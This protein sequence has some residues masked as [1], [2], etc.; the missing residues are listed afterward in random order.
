MR[1]RDVLKTAGASVAALA[2]PRIA[3]AER[4]N[5]LVVVPTT[6]L[7]VLDPVVTGLRSTRNHAYLVFDTL[8]GIDTSWTAQP[9]M[10]EGHQVEEDGLIW[11][12]T[13]RDGLR[14]HD[15]EPVL[16][17]DVVASIRRFAARISFANALMAATEELSGPDDHTVRFRLKRPFP[18]LPEA[19]AGPGA[20]VPA[21]MPERLAATSPFKPVA[22]IVGSGPYRFLPEEHISGAR[23]AYER[24]TLYQPRT[25]GPLGFTSGPKIAHFDRVEW[26][27]LDPFS[28]MAALQNGE[29]DWWEAPLHDQ[30]EALTRERNITVISQYATAM[31]ILRFNH[32]HPPFNNV[33]VRRALLGAVDQAEAMTAVAGTDPAFWR[34][35][36]GLFAAG[37][38]LANDAGVEVLRG[39][40]DYA[41][42]RRALARAGYNG[43]K[44][45]V[46]A[47]TD[48]QGIRALSLAGTDQLRRAGMNVDLQEMDLGTVL[49]RRT[50]QAAPDKGGWNAVFGLLDR[51]VPNT[52]PYGN[53][54]IRA[55]GL[56][57]FDG[58]PTSPLIEA[59]RAAWLDAGSID[60]QLRICTELQLQLWQDVPYIPMGEYWQSTAYRK[61][62]LDVLPGCFAVF[63]GVRRA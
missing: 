47:P 43:E 5:K 29:I 56:A 9:Q 15:K 39:P 10:V 52:N 32:L 1:R 38:P 46:L 53:M 20:N 12:L 24:F 11:T 51:S 59:L 8:Y 16:A 34:D 41:A 48:A 31:G 37:T 57:A 49:R 54:W 58:W 4:L 25:G 35:G 28:A 22:E 44:I 13:L 60:E 6:D 45:V 7:S 27:T 21:I 42:V 26:L 55:D 40:R 62:L 3:R 33:A 17:R 50:N 18:H 23:A 36:I 63:Y 2:A 30:A 14:F 19:L 61:D